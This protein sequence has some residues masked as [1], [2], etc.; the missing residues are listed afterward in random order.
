[1]GVGTNIR[2]GRLWRTLIASQT[3]KGTEIDDLRSATQTWAHASIVDFDGGLREPEWWYNYYNANY[4]TSRYPI[5]RL[6]LGG[7]FAHANPTL[8][9]LALQSLFGE[10]SAGTF[11]IKGYVN[12]WL[13]IAFVEDKTKTTSVA[14]VVR[15]MD[16]MIARLV[17][18]VDSTGYVEL[19]A[20]YAAERSDTATI[21]SLGSIQLPTAP[22]DTLD[23]DVFAGRS[24]TLTRDPDGTPVA[25]PFANLSVEMDVALDPYWD[26]CGRR[27]RAIRRGPVDVRLIVTGRPND[28]QWQMTLD[29]VSNTPQTYRVAMSANGHVLT[30][31]LHGV[32]FTRDPFGVRD[33]NYDDVTARGVATTDGTDFVD[34]TLT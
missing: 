17:F 15:M 11:T 31:D 20:Y 14:R 3:S 13:T 30:M 2:P 23:Q 25:I 32:T 10:L 12:K 22:M 4:R 26:Y 21:G 9:S 33:Q 5:N 28:E 7:I 18:D 19:M 24:V 29:S 34:I 27:E 8:S 6:A 16:A 1:M